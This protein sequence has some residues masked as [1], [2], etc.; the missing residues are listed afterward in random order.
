MRKSTLFI[1]AVLTSFMLAVLFVVVS[2]YKGIVDTAQTENAT[3]K[4]AAEAAV[5]FTD[6]SLPSPTASVFLT[7]EQAAALAAQVLGRTD[8]Y[9]VETT[10][11]NGVSVYL[12]TFVSGDLV[13]VSP[14]GMILSV[15][16]PTP[17]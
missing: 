7:P 2:A 15:V 9:S 8:L 14:E 12:V 17:V 6:A 5:A 11:F 3:T 4:A 16:A 10:L 13:Y 1:S